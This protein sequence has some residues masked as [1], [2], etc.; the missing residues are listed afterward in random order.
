MTL[1]YDGISE[2][3]K[4]HKAEFSRKE[5][6]SKYTTFH[7]GGS[8]D[9]LVK[10][11]SSACISEIFAACKKEKIPTYLIGRGSNLLVSDRGLRGLVIVLSD[12]F[13]EVTSDGERLL[14]CAGASLNKICVIARE[15]SLTGLEFAYGIPGTIGGALYMNAGAYGGEMKDVVEF[16]EYLDEKNEIKRMTAGEMKL[17][18]RK[19][20]FSE[21]KYPILRVS[22]KLK[23]GDRDAIAD[24]MS[25]LMAK[26]RN[27]QPLEYPSAGSTFKRPV[28]D[29]AARLIEA[30]GLKGYTCG[31]AAVSE[32]H[33]GFIVNLGDATSADVLNVVAA[34]KEKVFRDSGVRLE[35]EMMI[36]E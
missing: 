30:S 22:L 9:A 19:S 25:E 10:P 35:C 15:L 11:N 1:L 12:A 2:I 29:Y 14:C 21:K 6:L 16:C 26:R 24:R 13:S 34:V 20:V 27:S 28:G 18:Y 4:R 5:P 7:I 32:K 36:L 17:S 8:C 3:A 33:S 31:G 23:R